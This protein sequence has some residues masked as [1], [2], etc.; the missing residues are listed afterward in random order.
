MAN[1]AAPMKALPGMKIFKTAVSM[2]ILMH[3]SNNF[4]KEYDLLLAVSKNINESCSASVACN[5]LYGF[6]CVKGVCQC[7][8]SSFF[9]GIKCGK[10]T[11]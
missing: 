5:Q 2:M 7:N 1:A 3:F 9:N 11:L 8:Q 10:K 6:V 4:V